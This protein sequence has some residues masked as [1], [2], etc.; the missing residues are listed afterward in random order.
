MW[1]LAMTPGKRLA[2]PRSSTAVCSTV[3]SVFRARDGPALT[4]GPV[5][6]VELLRLVRDGDRPVDDLALQI[7]ELAL[8]VVEEPTARR[9]VDATRL[10][11]VDGRACDLLTIV[12]ALDGV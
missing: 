4:R 3:S 1:S 7:L 8:D 2:M 12:E 10:E 5:S 9:V 11:V 6:H